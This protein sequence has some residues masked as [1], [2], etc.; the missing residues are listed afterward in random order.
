MEYSPNSMSNQALHLITHSGK[1]SG[2]RSQNSFYSY[3]HINLTFL[4][5][6]LLIYKI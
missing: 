1:E 2:F 5:L 4:V 6:N 3:K